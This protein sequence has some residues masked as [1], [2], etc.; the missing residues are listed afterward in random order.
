MLQSCP[1]MSKVAFEVQEI[2]YQQFNLRHFNKRKDSRN[3]LCLISNDSDIFSLKF[4]R[5]KYYS[6]SCLL[7]SNRWKLI[8]GLRTIGYCPV[9]GRTD[10]K[11]ILTK[12]NASFFQKAFYYQLRLN[13]KSSEKGEMNF[14]P[15]KLHK[16][17]SSAQSCSISR[18]IPKSCSRLRKMLKGSVHNLSMPR[19]IPQIFC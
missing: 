2:A 18:A 7:A 13:S 12:Q 14:W 16:R 19:Y 5:S 4:K 8:Q 1:K 10:C 9:R 15:K 11:R 17:C 6:D 3:L